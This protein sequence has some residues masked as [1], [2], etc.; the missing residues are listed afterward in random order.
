MV[1]R[2]PYRIQTWLVTERITIQ[3]AED[4]A[5]ADRIDAL[6]GYLRD[7]LLEL[8]VADVRRGA[9]RAATWRTTATTTRD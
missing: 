2:R 9:G 1:P 8:D 6:T 5:D 3:I 7:A 4:G